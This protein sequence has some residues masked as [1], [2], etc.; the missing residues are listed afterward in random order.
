MV[1]TGQVTTLATAVHSALETNDRPTGREMVA[2]PPAVVGPALVTTTGTEISV[3]ASGEVV[4][5][6]NPMARSADA[7]TVTVTVAS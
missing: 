1:G 4:T 7:V 5:E 3:P 6:P 2:V